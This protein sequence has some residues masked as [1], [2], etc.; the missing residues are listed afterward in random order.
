MTDNETKINRNPQRLQ[1]LILVSG[2][3]ASNHFNSRQLGLKPD[4]KSKAS[5]FKKVIS[6]RM[7]IMV[8]F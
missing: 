2:K 7:V 4:A 1:A 5:V 6:G 8:A 3:V